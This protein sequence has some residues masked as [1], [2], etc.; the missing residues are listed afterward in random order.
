MEG[1][2]IQKVGNVSKE[3]SKR[4]NNESL[5]ILVIGI[6]AIVSLIVLGNPARELVAA[7]GGGLVGYLARS[8]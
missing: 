6:I 3:V 5:T 1:K 4:L 8:L 2:I 7:L